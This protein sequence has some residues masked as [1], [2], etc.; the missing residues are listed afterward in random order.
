M[1]K[2]DEV[3]VGIL[4]TAALA[5]AIVGSL[6]LARGGL[7]KGYPLYAKF[8]W[9][10]GLK[11]GQPVL[12]V[13]VNVGYVDNVE[14]KQNG[15]LVTTMRIV[16]DYKVPL[17]TSARVVANGI[18]GDMAIA[19]TPVKP[20]P[21]SFKSGDTIPVAPSAPGLSEITAKADSVGTSVNALTREM[22]REMVAGGGIRD[23]RQALAG[24]NRLIAQFTV[25]AAEQNRQLS[26]TQEA[27]RRATTAIDPVKIDSTVTNLR[28]A[29][30]NMAELTGDMKATTARI[31]SILAKV[32]HGDGTAAK[33]LNDPGVYNDVRMLLQRIDS[34]TADFKAN[35]RKYINLKIF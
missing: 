24:T 22:E 23:M 8:P 11:Q 7:S 28:T 10:A 21:Q 4:I 17:G 25:I 27:V 9:G 18:F 33:L 16:N 35:P 14:L 30:A 26:A 34:L 15:T 6:W 32:D 19:L 1:K 13:G 20:N 2:R 29:S 12:L 31:D 5:I 3:L